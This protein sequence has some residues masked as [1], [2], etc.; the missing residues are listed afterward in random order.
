MILGCNMISFHMHPVSDVLG[1]LP[2][3]STYPDV[4]ARTWKKRNSRSNLI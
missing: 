3:D 1:D 4:M 2:G